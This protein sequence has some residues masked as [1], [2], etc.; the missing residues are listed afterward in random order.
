MPMKFSNLS[1]GKKLWLCMGT[2]TFFVAVFLAI[3]QYA[4]SS[5]TTVFSRLIDDEFTM[6]ERGNYAKIA[7]LECRRNEKDVL[8]NDDESLVKKIL[9]FSNKMLDESRSVDSI[10]ARIS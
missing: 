4:L 7:F 1:V 5:T 9:A 8:Y 10:A 6:I 3:V 2:A